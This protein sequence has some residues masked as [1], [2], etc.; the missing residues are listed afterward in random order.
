MSRSVSE[1]KEAI[2]HLESVLDSGA[3]TVAQDGSTTVFDLDRA[4]ARLTDLKAELSTLQ[5]KK[6][7][8]RI[9]NSIDL[10]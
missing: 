3:T 5:G 10:S 2:A 4:A 1:I 6:K 7:R 8:R 9:F